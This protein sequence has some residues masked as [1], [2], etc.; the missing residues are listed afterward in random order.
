MSLPNGWGCHPN[1]IA[2]HIHIRYNQSVWAHW[3]ALHRHTEAALHLILA[4][5]WFRFDNDGLLGEWKWC[6]Y[7]MLEAAI[8]FK[9]LPPSILDIIIVFEPFVCCLKGRWVHSYT[10]PPAKLAPDLG[11]L[12]CLWSGKWCHYIMVEA[13]IQFKLLLASI[14]NIY[15]VFEP[16]ICFPK[17]CG[18]SLTPLYWSSWLRFGNSGSLAGQSNWCHYV[19]IEADIHLRSLHTPKLDIKCSSHWYAVS[20]AYGPTLTPFHRPSWPQIREFF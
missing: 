1:Q 20:R 3:W 11:L 15:K 16:L 6:H 12:D 8:L 5:G 14:S 4:N 13:A 18:S 2:S 9:L 10:T 17:A 7:I 19:M